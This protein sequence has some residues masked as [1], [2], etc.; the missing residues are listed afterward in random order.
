L[1]ENLRE[2]IIEKWFT[3][4]YFCSAV[5]WDFID[6][7]KKLYKSLKKRLKIAKELNL[8]ECVHGLEK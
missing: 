2:K 3:Y 6:T 4:E 5:Q 1:T 8:S 7:E